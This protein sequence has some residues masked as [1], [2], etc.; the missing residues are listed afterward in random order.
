MRVHGVSITV[1]A[2]QAV[3]QWLVAAVV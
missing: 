2:E 3:N 1:A